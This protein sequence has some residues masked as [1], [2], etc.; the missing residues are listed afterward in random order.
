[1]G[2]LRTEIMQ[3]M[4]VMKKYDNPTVLMLGKQDI[5][6]EKQDIVKLAKTYEF[7]LDVSKLGAENS[8]KIDSYE[9]FYAIGAKEVHAL[10]Y[11]D[12]ENADIIFDLNDRELPENLLE[13]YDIIIDGGVLE[14]LFCPNI[15]M[16]NL[17]KMLK[18]GGTVYHLVPCAGLV[19][20]GFY[21]FSPTFFLDYYK[22]IGYNI[23][24]IRMRYKPKRGIYEFVFYSMDCRLFLSQDEYNQYI[25]EYW[26]SGGEI[27][28]LVMAV[29]RNCN[30]I[31]Y[32]SVPIQGRYRNLYE[33]AGQ[34]SHSPQH[35]NLKKSIG[36][37]IRKM[38]GKDSQ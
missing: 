19:D 7:Y 12:Y 13:K 21:S 22:N 6:A 28:L 18:F 36:P 37:L 2:L 27:M 14:H 17:S 15:A 25:A 24:Q 34:T 1:M 31:N 20:H 5:Y 8:E 23:E 29:K 3:L 30:A 10:D 33:E 38:Q 4:S 32:E 9:L 35:L 11:S 26:N 16:V